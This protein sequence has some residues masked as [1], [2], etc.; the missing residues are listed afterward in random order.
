MRQAKKGEKFTV[1]GREFTK[2]TGHG[3]EEVKE[4]IDTEAY[5]RLKK[6]FDFSDYK[7]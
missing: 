3:E 6:V 4:A 2:T 7:G 5:D 1:G